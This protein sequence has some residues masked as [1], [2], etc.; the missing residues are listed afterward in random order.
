MTDWFNEYLKEQN[1]KEKL[2][3]E[4]EQLREYN[5][6][7]ETRYWEFAPKYDSLLIENERLKKV[8]EKLIE[9]ISDFHIAIHNAVFA[10][11]KELDGILKKDSE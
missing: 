4:I 9:A 11:D 1:E 10:F 6:A 8:N 3:A 2:K 7:I 5:D